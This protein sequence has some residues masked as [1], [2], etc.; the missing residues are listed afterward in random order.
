MDV[1]VSDLRGAFSRL[2]E[3]RDVYIPIDYHSQKPKGFAFIEYVRP[4]DARLAQEEMHHFVI[5]GKRMEVVFA[6]ERRKTPGEM[7]YKVES[8]RTRDN[9]RIRSDSYQKY[10]GDRNT[11]DRR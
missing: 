5:K 10:H 9:D 1:T 3:L 2:G 8:H 6:Q 11:S 4:E 7:K